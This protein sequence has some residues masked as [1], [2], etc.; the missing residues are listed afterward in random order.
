[1]Q[2]TPHV[3]TTIHLITTICEKERLAEVG[4]VGGSVDN[5]RISIKYI[6]THNNA[7]I[8]LILSII[9]DSYY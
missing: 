4:Q 8:L 5:L 1:M 3:T 6:I 9:H 2:L 7:I